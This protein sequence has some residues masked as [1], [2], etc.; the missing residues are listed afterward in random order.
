MESPRE[1]YQAL[2]YCKS[3]IESAYVHGFPENMHC[4]M[5]HAIDVVSSIGRRTGSNGG[6]HIL[7]RNT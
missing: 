3:Y 1:V 4:R 6:G 2:D 5:I 7:F